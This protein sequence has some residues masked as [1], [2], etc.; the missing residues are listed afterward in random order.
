MQQEPIGGKPEIDYPCQWEFKV[1]GT[2]EA[3]LRRAIGQIVGDR[4]HQLSVSNRSSGGKYC[5][6]RLEV[7]VEDEASRNAL[8]EALRDHED[9]T[10]LL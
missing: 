4:V 5:S 9:V 6:L 10:T 1:I 3:A 8:F 2:D 7:H